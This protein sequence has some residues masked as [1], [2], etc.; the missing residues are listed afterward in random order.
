VSAYVSVLE[1]L[2]SK[3]KKLGKKNVRV[4]IFC[5]GM[6]KTTK[7][8]SPPPLVPDLNG[9]F[10]DVSKVVRYDGSLQ[11]VTFL[12]GS[13]DALEA[14]DGMC[15]SDVLVTGNSA[16]SLL[17]AALC[18]RPVVLSMSGSGPSPY[19]YVPNALSL[20]VTKRVHDLSFVRKGFRASLT[21]GARFDE[22]RF[23]DLWSKRDDDAAAAVRR[24]RKQA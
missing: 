2:L 3:L 18:R 20:D 14:F 12:R 15:F 8:K 21:D 6:K 16:F 7:K 1:Q 10:V 11:S 5:E 23:D 17:A 4:H 9:T 19:D 22:G 24:A 13:P